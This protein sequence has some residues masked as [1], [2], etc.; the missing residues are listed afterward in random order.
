MTT[1][2]KLQGEYFWRKETGDLTYDSDGALG[3]TSVSNYSSR[4]S[5]WYRRRL[6]VHAALA[7]RRALR[8]AQ[9]GSVDYGANGITSR[10]NVQSAALFG[11]ARLHAVGVQPF[12]VQWQ[13]ARSGRTTYNQLFVQYI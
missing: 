9:H 12:R 1:N 5:G 6:P 3:L 11:D 10:R 7:R 13:Q 2:F 8:P 4:Q